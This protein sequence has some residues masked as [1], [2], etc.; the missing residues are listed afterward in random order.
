MSKR[1]GC[2]PLLSETLTCISATNKR[3]ASHALSWILTERPWQ[4]SKLEVLNVKLADE[5]LIPKTRMAKPF[6]CCMKQHNQR[7]VWRVR[8]KTH[9]VCNRYFHE[10]T[11]LP[12]RQHD[13][14]DVDF[15]HRHWVHSGGN[16]HFNPTRFRKATN[17]QKS[18]QGRGRRRR[19]AV[20]VKSSAYL[21]PPTYY[22]AD[23][24][25]QLLLEE[26]KW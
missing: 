13:D 16:K 8:E 15:R 18:E 1:T 7:N 12:I 25:R 21:V 19:S 20:Y 24:S 10:L 11:L 4:I 2:P 5:P 3:T 26:G 14:W 23:V 17:E 6:K 9:F 22:I